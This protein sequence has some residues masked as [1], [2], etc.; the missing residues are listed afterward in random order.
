MT[1]TAPHAEALA[2]AIDGLVYGALTIAGSRL[3]TKPACPRSERARAREI[4][5]SA[6]YV[7][8]PVDDDQVDAWKLLDG[9]WA[10][11]PEIAA[12]YDLDPLCLTYALDGYVR[13]LM[14]ARIPFAYDD[15]RRL[16]RMSPCTRKAAA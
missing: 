1:N 15:V 13:G 2:A 4:H 7:E 14:A 5:P 10:R 16:L 9:A 11:V 3:L 12:R 6:V 8:F